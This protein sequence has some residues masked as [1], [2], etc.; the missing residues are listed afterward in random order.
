MVLFVDEPSIANRAAG[1][2]APANTGE[3]V[4]MYQW[5]VD[6]SYGELRDEFRWDLPAAFN[7]GT[8]C[9]D[10]HAP[11]DLALIEL[12]DAHGERSFT[13]GDLTRLSNRF[14]NGLQ[15]VGVAA[16][17]RIGI[18]LPQRLETGVAHLAAWKMGAVT[19]PMSGLFGPDALRYRLEDSGARAVITD[20]R[21]LDRVAEV[22]AGIDGLTVIVAE[23]DVSAPHRRFDDLA[24]QG[25]DT[26]EAAPTTPDSPGLLIYTSGT[27]GAPKG[28][29]HGHRVL[30]GHLPGFDLA[31]DLYPQPGDRM[32]TPA[33]WA[34][35]G[36][37][38]D[39]LMP[40]WFHGTPAVAAPRGGFDPEWAM[41]LMAEHRVT[42][43]FLPPTA[44]KLMRQAGVGEPGVL[45]AILSG[46]E[47]LG[48]QMLD[49]GREHLGVTINEIFGQTEANLL[50]GNCAAAWEV[51][52]GST[53]LPY[54]GHELAVMDEQGNRLPP[55]ELGE[56]VLRTP[57][58]VMFLEYWN[59]PEATADKV[60]DGWLR[61]G[62]LGKVDED[63]YFWFASRTDDV[64]NSAGYRIGPAE[65][66][67]CLMKHPAV[68]MAA[69]IGVPDE[70]RGQV[71]KA[72]IKLADGHQPSD[73]LRAD[74]ADLVRNR[75]AAYEYPREIE[76]VDELPMT[77]TGKIRRLELKQREE[78]RR[79]EPGRT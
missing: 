6:A 28:A 29:L 7:M 63:G 30:L 27:T 68:A 71:V 60:R 11:D 45:R 35:I 40:A 4:A 19:V 1:P 3:R 25:S 22:A 16:G 57:D 46:G 51:R 74:V 12:T 48:E 54:P 41:R 64:I 44:L 79:Q 17:D 58:P 65:I 8:A 43:S 5:R 33:D 20:H 77:T 66:E 61:T 37:L 34:W 23:D 10:R 56:I 59:R 9:A 72:F 47:P 50:I 39:A 42:A 31:F 38:M 73:D 26:L 62:D 49:W 18:V 15:G 32:W 24:E 76:F 70:V 14:A 21:A 36:G 78:Q 67:E 55:G 13:F 69:A 52:P 2:Y 53:G 75:L